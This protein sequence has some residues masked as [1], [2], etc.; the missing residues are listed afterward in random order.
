MDWEV[1]VIFWHLMVNPNPAR[2]D[3]IVIFWCAV[4]VGIAAKSGENGYNFHGNYESEIV[5]LVHP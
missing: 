3:Q 4:P 2:L 1:L 5:N